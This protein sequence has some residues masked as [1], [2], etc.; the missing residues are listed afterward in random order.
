[1]NLKESDFFPNRRI[2]FWIR[3]GMLIRIKIRDSSSIALRQ[4]DFPG[5]YLTFSIKESLEWIFLVIRVSSERTEMEVLWDER[6]WC[7]S[8]PAWQHQCVSIE[9]ATYFE[10]KGVEEG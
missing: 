1:M 9:P 5:R 10:E 2:P 3:E 8:M 4:R 6:V 7:F